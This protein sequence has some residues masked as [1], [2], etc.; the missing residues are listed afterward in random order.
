MP[1]NVGQISRTLSLQQDHH[2]LHST[3]TS[4]G[5]PKKPQREPKSLQGE[6][7]SGF[8]SFDASST[9]RSR[10]NDMTESAGSG[11]VKR[12]KNEEAARSGGAKRN[13]KDEAARKLLD[14]IR[15]SQHL[16]VESHHINVNIDPRNEPTAYKRAKSLAD[17]TLQ[18]ILNADH[19]DKTAR[20]HL[21]CFFSF[22]VVQED[23]KRITR[24]ESNNLLDVI[25]TVDAS[26]E[27]RSRLK[28][29][30]RWMHSMLIMGLCKKGWPLDEATAIVAV[31]MFYTL[32]L[33]GPY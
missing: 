28:S 24:E 13:K 9:Q 2:G 15:A 4:Q 5:E 6:R 23:L 22:I 3:K 26:D 20:S 10:R 14:E 21:F 33:I 19:A 16:K 25:I 1:R 8:V 18:T 27:Y 17:A 29:G 30:I 32:D 11:G 31:C 12:N 7:T